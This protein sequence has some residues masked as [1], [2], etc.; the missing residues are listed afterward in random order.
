[1]SLDLA[2]GQ[3]LRV[4]ADHVRSQPLQTSR[5][6]GYRDRLEG[7]LTVPRHPQLHRSDIGPHRLGIGAIATVPRT[8]TDR[9]VRLVAQ[10]VGHL[11]I[12]TGLQH[13]AD[14]RRQQTVLAGQ[15]HA[16]AASTV[17]ESLRPRP[18]P[19]ALNRHQQRR[20][21]CRRPIIALVNRRGSRCIPHRHDPPSRPAHC[22]PLDHAKYTKFRTDPPLRQSSVEHVCGHLPSIG[23]HV[24]ILRGLGWLLVGCGC[25]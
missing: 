25:W 21:R 7:A 8:P 14:H 3:S 19:I 24:R 23:G 16:L 11:D 1:M 10:M 4:E 22:G 20:W 2:R 12:Q 18:H 6:L 15:R 9:L 13:L 17:D 5:V